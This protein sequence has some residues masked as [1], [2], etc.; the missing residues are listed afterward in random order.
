VPRCWMLLSVLILPTSAEGAGNWSVRLL[1]DGRVVYLSLWRLE[2]APLGGRRPAVHARIHG[3]SG[4]ES[5][6]RPTA[7]R[8]HAA[9]EWYPLSDELRLKP[10]VLFKPAITAASGL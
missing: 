2:S 4:T 8:V 7:T 3:Q 10:S 5:I 1:V 6:G 9:D